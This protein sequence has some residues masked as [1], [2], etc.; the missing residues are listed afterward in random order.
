MHLKIEHIIILSG[1]VASCFALIPP[2]ADN[3]FY[4]IES[5]YGSRE[6]GSNRLHLSKCLNYSQFKEFW[7]AENILNDDPADLYWYQNF[8]TESLGLLHFLVY[9]WI[10]L[11]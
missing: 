6:Q 9:K 3:P 5:Y 2:G 4:K 11:K 8:F 10:T 7:I 1:L